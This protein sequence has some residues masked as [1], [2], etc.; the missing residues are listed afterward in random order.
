[1]NFFENYSKTGVGLVI[2]TVIELIIPLTG[3][4]VPEG[5]AAG[6]VNT[7]AA[8]VGYVLLFYGQWDRKDLANGLKRK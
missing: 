3:I 8:F 4:K 2:V 1:M 6:V 7:I 5:T